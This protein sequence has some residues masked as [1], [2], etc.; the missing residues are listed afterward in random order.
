MRRLRSGQFSLTQHLQ[1]GWML[2]RWSWGLGGGLTFRRARDLDWT[3]QINADPL[4]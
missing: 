1:Q 4:I 3:E 2:L